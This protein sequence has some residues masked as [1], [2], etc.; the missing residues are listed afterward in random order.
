MSDS[1]SR[2]QQTPAEQVSQDV[3][4]RGEQPP[5]APPPRERAPDA[6][7]AGQPE[8]RSDPE[9]LR[10]DIVETRAEL[11]ETVEAL[12]EKVDVKAQAKAKIE[13]QKAQLRQRREQAKAKLT[14]V[15]AQ[16]K[17]RPGPLV[18]AAGLLAVV[19]LLRRLRRR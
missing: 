9:A 4:T 2:E 17:Q 11:G 16:A 5:T 3:A 13:E 7:A 19:M 8:P 12:A 1:E 15:T 18:A 6:P 10:E 14:E